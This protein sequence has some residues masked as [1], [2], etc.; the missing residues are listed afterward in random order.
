MHDAI[1]TKAFERTFKTKQKIAL[2]TED[3]FNRA[4]SKDGGRTTAEEVGESGQE[5]EQWNLH[6]PYIMTL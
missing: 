1:Y 2:R 4:I 5:L 6:S 3:I